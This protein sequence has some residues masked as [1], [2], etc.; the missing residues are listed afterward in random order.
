MPFLYQEKNLNL[1]QLLIN[2]KSITDNGEIENW[3]KRNRARDLYIKRV[4][5]T[6]SWV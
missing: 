3:N 1:N 4:S 5:H 6:L 2:Y